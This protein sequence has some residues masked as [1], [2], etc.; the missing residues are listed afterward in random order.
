VRDPLLRAFDSLELRLLLRNTM[1]YQQLQRHLLHPEFLE[2]AL[3][4]SIELEWLARPLCTRRKPARG[5]VKVYE[6]ERAAMEQLDVPHFTTSTWQA[7]RHHPASEEIKSFG[8][9]RDSRTL[10]RRLAGLSRTG[11]QRQLALITRSVCLKYPALPKRVM[12]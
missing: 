3:D 11:Y 7:M 12:A 2:N 9:K 8:S 10:R 4:R 6:L 1:T 5:R